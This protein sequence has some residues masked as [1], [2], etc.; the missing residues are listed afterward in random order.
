[1]PNMPASKL[2]LRLLAGAALVALLQPNLAGAATVGTAGAANTRST[3]TP[4]GGNLRVIEIG[5]QVVTNEKIETSASG[6]VQLLFIDKTTL[7]IGPN[8]S[9]VIDKF[10]FNP[11]TAQ[12]EVA[13]TLGKGVLRVVGG[14]AT[15]TGGGTVT[16]PVA[17]IGIRGG[18]LTAKHTPGVC[19]G[20]D[21]AGQPHPCGTQAILG[22]GVMSMTSGGVTQTVTRPGFFVQSSS[23]STPPSQPAK[24]S[25]A[26]TDGTNA[27][28]TSK[29]GQSGG[30]SAKPS[31]QQAAANNIGTGTSV[32]APLVITPT[33]VKSTTIANTATQLAGQG[34]QSTSSI[35]TTE[36]VIAANQSPPPPPPP[37]SAPPAP[38]A[39]RAATAAATP[40][41]DGHA[42]L[43]ARHDGR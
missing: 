9:I 14:Q 2:R 5:S 15:H 40:Q 35:V 4:P 36:Q 7:S 28:L 42:R 1:M 11:A 32:A 39:P 29:G 17:T 26:L 10:V 13:V 43:C 27:A 3:G 33:T 37:A 6:S 20:E 25:A 21:I 24:A 8:S 30:S 12:G 34:A 19:S 41:A 16:T 22:Y 18:I 38:P 31:D 23:A